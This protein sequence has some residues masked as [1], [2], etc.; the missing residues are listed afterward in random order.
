MSSDFDQRL[1][2]ILGRITADDFLKGCVLGSE[3]PFYAFDYPPEQE[4]A[5]RAHIAFVLAQ[6]HKQRQQGDRA[7][8]EA[9]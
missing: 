1:T 7:L 6:V 4:L 3:I 9:A 8:L 2:Q 5:V